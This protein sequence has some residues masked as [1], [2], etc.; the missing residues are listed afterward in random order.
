MKIGV[1]N[2]HD[3]PRSI[4]AASQVGGNIFRRD[5]A[6]IK[7]GVRGKTAFRNF[8]D[9][10]GCKGNLTTSRQVDRVREPAENT[11]ALA[12]PLCS[13]SPVR[14]ANPAEKHKCGFLMLRGR[15]KFTSRL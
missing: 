14:I 13:E 15:L 9:R 4:A 2:I 8:A 5:Q 7:S 11:R 12:V 3:L 10:F 1:N 6:R